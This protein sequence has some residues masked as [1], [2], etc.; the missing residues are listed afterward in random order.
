MLFNIKLVSRLDK[1]YL[2][3]LNNI[4]TVNYEKSDFG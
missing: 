2:I 4:I 1:Y 3:I